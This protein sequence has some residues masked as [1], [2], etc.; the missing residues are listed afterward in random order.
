MKHFALG[1]GLAVALAPG[2]F[3]QDKGNLEI[4]G[5]IGH[6][7][8]VAHE[9]VY[10][11]VTGDKVSE[12][13]WDMQNALAFN[14]D[15]E[16]QATSALKF[17][18]KATIGL[19]GDNYMDDYDW[20]NGAPPAPFSHHS[21]HDDTTLDHYFS[22]DAGAGYAFYDTGSTQLSVLGGFKYTDVKWTASG[23]CLSYD[24]GTPAQL[25]LCF[26]DGLDVITYQQKLPAVYAGLG[27]DTQLDAWTF[28]ATA[29]GGM[30][31]GGEAPDNHWLRDL[32]FVDDLGSAPYISLR[33]KAAY[34]VSETVS[35][36]GSVEYDKY[37]TMKGPTTI[38]DTTG[39]TPPFT[40]SGDSGG[41][42]LYTV[43]L[44][45]G[46]SVRF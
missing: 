45:V 17:Y 5:S 14:L 27:L 31:F 2:A 38:T 4:S 18:G 42:S 29:L 40:I 8:G 46:A 28:S 35:F 24:I 41:A 30:S 44:A 15:A 10:D 43:N 22:V 11:T 9:Y 36:F 25:D 37:F 16:W 23:G 39:A 34:A 13:V 12:L 3:A 1:V 32:Y 7:S 33:G 19:N 6:L 20:L 26:P 21:W